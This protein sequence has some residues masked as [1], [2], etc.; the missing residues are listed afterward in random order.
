M[1][2]VKM[3]ITIGSD[4]EFMLA[5]VEEN[6]KHIDAN[7]A[8]TKLYSEEFGSGQYILPEQV[9]TKLKGII[10]LYLYNIDFF[11]HIIILGEETVA[12]AI[13]ELYKTP[14]EA[15]LNIPELS[16]LI[17]KY[18]KKPSDQYY[19]DK[20]VYTD[21]FD[22]RNIFVPIGKMGSVKVALIETFQDYLY[23]E[24]C[25]NTK[26]VMSRLYIILHNL[27]SNNADYYHHITDKY[28]TNF[29]RMQTYDE[30]EKFEIPN[31]LREFILEDE[32]HVK[33]LNELKYVQRPLNENELSLVQEDLLNAVIGC[34]G[35]T[36]V[37]ELRPYHSSNPINHFYE[38]RELIQDIYTMAK[39]KDIC[40]GKTLGMYSGGVQFFCRLGGHI[41]IGYDVIDLFN[42]NRYDAF[43]SKTEN[44]F[45]FADLVLSN[46]ITYY[47]SVLVGVPL[48]CISDKESYEN[49][50]LRC[51][52][53]HEDFGQFGSARVKSYG[54]EWRMPSSWLLTPELCLMV[55]TLSYVVAYEAI[56]RVINLYRNRSDTKITYYTELLTNRNDA[57]DINEMLTGVE[58]VEYYIQSEKLDSL[59]ATINPIYD[60]IKE[61]K[62]YKENS[63]YKG[64]IDS[65][66]YKV[67][68][69][70]VIDKNVNIFDNWINT[71]IQT[72]NK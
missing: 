54:V 69:N 28:C 67:K 36:I 20:L 68:N 24:P 6:K 50:H 14:Y 5:C 37:G 42:L 59:K 3:Y 7:K 16:D 43:L 23:G 51:Y 27:S 71:F 31:D 41:H 40:S 38:I 21:R 46:V 53:E 10:I 19:N 52:Y 49:R 70:E 2:V 25:E 47:L 66:F 9:E 65:F 60:H 72:N 55:L 64:I 63:N 22:D 61:M 1:W 39:E 45:D 17:D 29:L 26:S 62:L 33:I 48:I 44:N 30:Y 56:D 58:N 15:A 34:D 11:E 35:N 57:Q 18:T 32:K 13:I 12:N 4:P 8:I